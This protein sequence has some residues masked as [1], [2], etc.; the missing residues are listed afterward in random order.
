MSTAC[1]TL[2]CDP[3]RL[4]ALDSSLTP[5]IAVSILRGLQA[6]VVDYLGYDPTPVTTTEYLSGYGTDTAVLRQPASSVLEVR[7]DWYGH[8]GTT[9]EGFQGLPA[10]TATSAVTNGVVTGVTLVSG[11]SGY[12]QIPNVIFVGGGGADAAATATV[13]NGVV[14][15]ITLTAGGENYAAAPQVAIDSPCG[16][17][18]VL[19][20]GQDYFFQPPNL[21]RRIR[22]V[23]DF[24]WQVAPDRLAYTLEPARGCI[25]VTYTVGP[26]VPP[27]IVEAMY[28]EAGAR[29]KFQQNLGLG[30][31][32]NRSLGDV[33]FSIT[34]FQRQ[35]G[36][37]GP[38]VTPFLTDQLANAL[39]R[40]KRRVIAMG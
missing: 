13:V 15:S 9:P 20:L 14:T 28:A 24:R 23:W 26:C 17:S 6:A 38:G 1:P 40:R 27:D 29:W 3:A 10:A 25:R 11:S 39:F 35:T 37:N 7:Q 16:V 12:T 33:S 36:S 4:V 2:W 32:G 18:T 30:Y 34:P 21:L 22:T 19:T 5:E 8:A 31:K